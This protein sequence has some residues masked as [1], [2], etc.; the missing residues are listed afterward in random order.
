MLEQTN[1]WKTEWQEQ[2]IEVKCKES[3][4]LLIH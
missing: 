3:F 1:T 4:K 2:Q